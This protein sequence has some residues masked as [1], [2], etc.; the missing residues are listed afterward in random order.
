MGPPVQSLDR[1]LLFK[2][3]TNEELLK[4]LNYYMN[5]DTFMQ[6]ELWN[7]EL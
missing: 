5:K 7:G 4:V 6:F 3:A 2:S 1:R